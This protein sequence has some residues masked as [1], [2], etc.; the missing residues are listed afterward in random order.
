MSF[1]DIL[2]VAIIVV[3]VAAG[4]FLVIAWATAE[5]EKHRGLPLF[6]RRR[7]GPWAVELRN[8]GR[9]RL[10]VVRL[11]REAS[12]VGLRVARGLVDNTPS[13]V[14]TGVARSDAEELVGRLEAL[15]AEAV[16]MPAAEAL[17][18]EVYDTL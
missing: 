17:E 9:K 18:D 14:L 5:A 15:G 13:I 4:V 3:M 8:P 10:A 1:Q 7:P 12:G 16:I 6:E 11:V 2:L